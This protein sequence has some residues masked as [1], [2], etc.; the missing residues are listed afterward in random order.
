MAFWALA[1]VA[2][3]S[4]LPGKTKS[5]VNLTSEPRDIIGQKAHRMAAQHAW[6]LR[7]E[8]DKGHPVGVAAICSAHP[9][10]I[11]VALQYA[12]ARNSIVL[13]EATCNQ[14]N[15]LGGYTG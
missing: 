2:S 15:H 12:L 4:H 1:S 14:V 8:R 10:V 6:D 7:L 5:P 11:E 3:G 13:I 9:A